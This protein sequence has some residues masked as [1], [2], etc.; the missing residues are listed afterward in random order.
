MRAFAPQL[1]DPKEQRALL[2]AIDEAT[3]VTRGSTQ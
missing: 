3:L 2:E 1:T